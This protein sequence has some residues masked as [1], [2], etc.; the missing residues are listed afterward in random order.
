MKNKDF[1]PPKKEPKR[2]YVSPVLKK[3]GSVADL[4]LKGGSQPD[5]SNG[6]QL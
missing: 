2:K 3:H 1:T 4:T 6:Y 5:F